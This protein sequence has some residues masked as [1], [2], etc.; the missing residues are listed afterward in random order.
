MTPLCRLVGQSSSLAC[1]VPA[2]FFIACI[3]IT[4]MRSAK[5]EASMLA[6][7]L[8]LPRALILPYPHAPLV[9]NL[10][11]HP[12]RAVREQPSRVDC[13]NKANA[14]PWL[15]TPA[16]ATMDHTPCLTPIHTHLGHSNKLSLGRVLVRG[17]FPR[18]RYYLHGVL[19]VHTA[20]PPSSITMEMELPI[21][22]CSPNKHDIAFRGLDKH[23]PEPLPLSSV[24]SNHP[25][26]SWLDCH[27]V[28][29]L[30]IA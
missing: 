9:A 15:W 23:V 7:P 27:C 22:R 18:G 11:C 12:V 13:R 20:R 29:A 24:F 5:I 14:A 6:M 21:F 30:I 3:T 4:R 26:V 2:T 17:V 25:L 28:A 8:T 1:G 10:P 19:L 16:H